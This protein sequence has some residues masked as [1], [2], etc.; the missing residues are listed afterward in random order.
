MEA[1]AV[2]ASIVQ[3]AGAGLA[4][5]KV[6]YGLCDE[7]SSSKAQIKE[8]AFSVR[9][10][11][12]VLEEIGKIFQDESTAARQLISQNAIS[13]T[14]EIVEKCTASFDTLQ[15][16][17]A[18]AGQ[19]TLGLLRFMMK[20]S[21]L[22]VLQSGL[23]EMRS[24]L[25][26]MMQ[27][28]IYARLKAEPQS[29][30]SESSQ[31]KMIS[32]LFQEHLKAVE[33][34]RA[35]Q[36]QQQQSTQQPADEH[37]DHKETQPSL[38][39]ISRTSSNAREQSRVHQQPLGS[40]SMVPWTFALQPDSN[41]ASQANDES[42]RP[43]QLNQTHRSPGDMQTPSDDTISYLS[44]LYL[45]CCPCLALSAG[46]EVVKST[47]PCLRASA[48]RPIHPSRVMSYPATPANSRD[49]A[50][51]YHLAHRERHAAPQQHSLMATLSV[52]YDPATSN[53][54]NDPNR[55]VSQDQG[56]S[57][58][59]ISE[60]I[61]QSLPRTSSNASTKT[62]FFNPPAGEVTSAGWRNQQGLD[63]DV[64]RLVQE[65]TTLYD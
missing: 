48:P 21:T 9:S 57:V 5:A 2:A 27:V 49:P 14:K 13:T 12:V 64:D 51:R 11:T 34:H 1:F 30:F 60:T 52:D 26:C 6:L 41:V 7:T 15:E 32:D 31:R 24:N 29:S 10:T 54:T 36:R 45:V 43:G 53:A 42:I 40:H 65:W 46:T 16:I 37:S 25:Q 22:K 23:G 61:P 62:D 39:S 33:Q 18:S 8:L 44:A 63:S 59:A 58:S 28:I 20:G 3:V 55:N 19:N 38:N 4:L 50:I 35:A 17:V 56:S 47:E